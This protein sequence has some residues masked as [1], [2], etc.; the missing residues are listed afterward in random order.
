[1]AGTGT[2]LTRGVFFRPAIP[3]SSPPPY[4]AMPANWR[5]P[6]LNNNGNDNR[7]HPSPSPPPPVGPTWTPRNDFPR[8]VNQWNANP[9][10]NSNRK[11]ARIPLK[12]ARPARPL[13]PL[14]PGAGRGGPPGGGNVVGRGAGPAGSVDVPAASS[15]PFSWQRS[16]GATTVVGGRV[17]KRPPRGPRGGRTVRVDLPDDDSRPRRN[18]GDDEA[19]GGTRNRLQRLVDKF[20]QFRLRRGRFWKKMAL[21]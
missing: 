20:R 17:G 5:P 7:R 19:A 16:P 2:L 10:N 15:R 6:P 18:N 11:S 8:D 3:I 13:P 14:P 1:M 21:L 12:R 9:Q 4:Q